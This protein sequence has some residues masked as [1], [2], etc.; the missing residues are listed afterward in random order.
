MRETAACPPEPLFG[1]NLGSFVVCERINDSMRISAH[2]LAVSLIVITLISVAPAPLRGADKEAEVR[3]TIEAFYKAFNDG[4]TKPADYAADD[5]NHIDPL[6]GRH[7]G[8][9]AVLKAVREVHQSFLKGAT[10]TLESMNI[11][12]ATSEVAV[13]TVVSVGKSADGKSGR[14]I[15]TFVVVRR[16]KRWQ[17]MQDH[18]TLIQEPH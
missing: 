13:G 5:W 2:S 12:F 11:R 4:F 7:R 17:I 18:N 1:A 6:G 16:G 14:G 15:R 9:E 10:D 8:R 3:S